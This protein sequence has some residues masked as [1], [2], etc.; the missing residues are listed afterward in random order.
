[1]PEGK[2]KAEE[3]VDGDALTTV[4][5]AL[6]SLA[7]SEKIDD[8]ALAKISSVVENLNEST[9]KAIL[10]LPAMQAI[11]QKVQES[12][13]A[14]DVQPGDYVKVG[15]FTFKKPY[16]MGDLFKVWGTEERFIAPRTEVVVTP[17]G[18]QFRLSEGIIYD[19]PRD[20]VMEAIPEGHGYVLPKVVAQILAEKA[21]TIRQTRRDTEGERG[22]GAGVKFLGTGWA[23]KDSIVTAS[24]RDAH[25]TP[26][27]E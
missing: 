14:P 9:Q 17:G 24:D 5:A 25:P 3:A 15:M 22:F 4:T 1:M 8:T 7:D 13:V 23:G 26:T 11:I 10:D 27:S 12:A 18:W 2:N 21:Q 20:V 6:Q 19:I 16:S